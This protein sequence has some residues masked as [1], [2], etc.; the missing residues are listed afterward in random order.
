MVRRFSRQRVAPDHVTRNS[1]DQQVLMPEDPPGPE[2][3]VDGEEEVNGRDRT[4]SAVILDDDGDQSETYAV[5][6]RSGS[7]SSSESV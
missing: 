7:A 3:E 4:S 1:H 6:L 5:E 2:V